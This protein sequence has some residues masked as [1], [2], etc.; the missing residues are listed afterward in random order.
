MKV[1]EKNLAKYGMMRD[2]GFTKDEIRR[3]F[4]ESRRKKNN[5]VGASTA[6]PN[7]KGDKV[8]STYKENKA[9]I[10]PTVFWNMM[11]E[12]KSAKEIAEYF[13]CSVQTVYNR[14]TKGRP[15]IKTAKDFENER[16][17]EN[18]AV[19]ETPEE[20]PV[21]DDA[22]GVPTVEASAEPPLRAVEAP[23]PTEDRDI[24]EV[25]NT[26]VEITSEVNDV[27]AIHESPEFTDK[28]MGD[29]AKPDLLM[30]A[31]R[32]DSMASS[33]GFV[34]DHMELDSQAARD[35][36]RVSGVGASGKVY[37]IELSVTDPTRL[38]V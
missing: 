13:G 7:N 19:T 8:M 6:R 15:K 38:C 37:E 32:A 14:I 20:T 21:G 31:I 28:K 10:N 26:E 2:A 36:M 17:A 22:L 27:E 33:A 29:I 12:G 25:H 5:N 35:F 24:T 18:E 30:L 4:G 16:A 9:N 23:A 3:E 11:D 34:P 1:T